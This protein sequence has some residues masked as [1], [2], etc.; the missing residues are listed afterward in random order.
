MTMRHIK[1]SDGCVL[2][3]HLLRRGAEGAPPV[4][5]LHALAMDAQMWR[6]VSE[7]IIT[8][9][10]VYALDCR[11]H[12]ASDKPFGPYTIARF[13]QDVIEVIDSLG[14]VR[15]HVAGCSMGGTVA[16]AVAGRYPHRVASL[17]VIDST[18]WYGMDG[19]NAWESRAQRALTD[20]LQ[21]LVQFQL[22]RWFSTGFASANPTLAA[23][24]VKV[25]IGN[26]VNA[27]ASSCRM[28]GQADER[29]QLGCYTGPACVVVG[30]E[31]YATPVAMSQ[32]IVSQLRG[33]T[34]N[35]LESVRH[36]TPIEV[37]DQVAR[38]LSAV[39]ALATPM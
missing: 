7:K 22:E 31:D 28:L 20:G 5:L 14:A 10:P 8:D 3:L 11:G 36:Y 25:F 37:P 4:V 33:A 1:T 21:S 29:A 27:Y 9:V 16:M 15:A 2:A 34:L 12:G 13:A 30:R 23:G 6:A 19:P 35:I 39:I 18:A 32:D 38:S 26:D 17:A 24:A